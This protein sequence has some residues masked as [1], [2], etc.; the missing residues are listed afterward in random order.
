MAN[1]DVSGQLATAGL[2]FG[3][4]V[5][6]TGQAVANTQTAL[7]KTGADATSALATTLVDVI[8]VQELDYDDNG[9]VTGEKTF[10]QQLPLIDFID[11]VIYQWTQVRLQGRFTASQF[12]ATASTDTHS[13]TST[14]S[15]GQAGFGIIFGGGYNNFQYDDSQT[16]IDTNFRVEDSVGLLRMNAVLEPRHDIGV[17]KPRQAIVGPQIE[18]DA[19]PIA[20]VGNPATSRTMDAVITYRNAAGDPI[21][22]KELAIDTQGV[23]WAFKGGTGT[24]DAN[25]QVTITLTR[26]FVGDAPDRTPADFVVG[27]RKGIVGESTTLT[28]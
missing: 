11:P 21:A 27:V 16:H 20:D 18:I 28:F 17:P 1:T 9:N 19:G 22:G 14:D 7:N 24:T 23:A 6:L 8:A 2:A 26:Q 12:A 5:K 3:D 13:N 4:L 15:S 25:G 10:T